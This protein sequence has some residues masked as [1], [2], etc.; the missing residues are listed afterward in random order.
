MAILL[1]AAGVFSLL[2][3]TPEGKGGLGAVNVLLIVVD[4][5]GGEHVGCSCYTEDTTP[6]FD[7]LA[8]RGVRFQRAYSTAPWTKPAVASIFTGLFPSTHGVRELGDLLNPGQVVLAETLRDRG[9]RTAGIVSHSLVSSN[10]GYGQGFESYDDS[11]SE[12]SHERISSADVSDRALGWLDAHHDEPFF[13]F[14]HY[15]DP[16]YLYH[17]H[18]DFDRTSE[19]VGPLEAAMDIWKLR[20]KRGQLTS[21]DINFLA[22]LYHEEIAYTDGQIGLVLAHLETLG[23]E[24]R[25]LVVLTADH[26]EEFM[27]HGWIGH[28]RTL[29]EELIR[30]PLIISL[31][32]TIAPREVEAPVSTTDIAPT[33]LALVGAPVVETRWDGVSLAPLLL[34]GQGPG[35]DRRIVSE[36]S[37][38]SVDVA[39][40]EE[41]IAYKTS[42][43]RDRLKVIHDRLGDSWEVYDLQ[44][45]RL[46]QENVV[47]NVAS[48]GLTLMEELVEW[49][50][51]AEPLD[52]EQKWQPSEEDRER[53]R[54]LGYVE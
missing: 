34:R 11:L 3:V 41:K 19:Y 26:G 35:L 37:F 52:S 48:D 47:E 18:P 50:K 27:R 6:H 44:S 14:L 13:L 39:G 45:D 29:Y 40:H 49:E 46:E 30:V 15:F 5:L 43:V 36:V 54:A 22:G 25:T 28:T 16:H 17:H 24:G 4:T 53:M 8:E 2:R 21:D 31:P 23:I 1:A 42:M 51:Q 7:R 12:G 33:I 9:Y 10:H 20:E 38:L 32:G